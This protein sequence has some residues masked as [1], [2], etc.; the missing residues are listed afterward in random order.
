VK[1]V[2]PKCDVVYDFAGVVVFVDPATPPARSRS[3]RPSPSDPGAPIMA[4]DWKPVRVPA[5]LHARLQAMADVMLKAQVEGKASLPSE[6]CEAV[7]LHHVIDTALAEMEG[8][9]ERSK[10]SKRSKCEA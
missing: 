9:R 4:Q 6:Y 10:A 1:V 3:A 7:P 5:E 2:K 8:H